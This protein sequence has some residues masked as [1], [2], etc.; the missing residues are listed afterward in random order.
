[1]LLMQLTLGLYLPFA[2]V[3]AY[4]LKVESVTLHVK[5]SLCQLAGRLAEAGGGLG[6]AAADA[7][8]LDLV[9]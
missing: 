7:V 4:R 8:G 5:G 3:A 2:R 1:M 6:D 9:G